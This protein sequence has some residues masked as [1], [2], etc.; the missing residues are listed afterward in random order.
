V[1]AMQDNPARAWTEEELV[2]A[3]QAQGARYH[4]LHPFH[5]RM[6][7]GELSPDEI[8]RWVANRYYYQKCIPLKDA[9]IL[10]NCPDM[11]VRRE[12]VQ[13]ILDHDGVAPVPGGTSGPGAHGTVADGPDP[14]GGSRGAP[15]GGGIE[16]WLRL[17]EAVGLSRE[18]LE[19]ERQVLPGVRFAVDAYVVF[20]RTRPWIEAVASSLTELFGPDAIRVRLAALERH[21]PWIER[22]GLAYFRDRLDQAPRDARY[23]LGLVLRHCRTREQQARAVAALALKC[24]ILWAQLDAIERGD[25]RPAAARAAP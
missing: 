12:W 2:A 24:D 17:G 21:Y 7:A 11:A 23:A 5:V 6:N 16:K 3:L 14:A 22:A 4:H 1:L 13:R 15:A 20:C 9:A 25:T 8:Q 19:G 10:S 18:Q